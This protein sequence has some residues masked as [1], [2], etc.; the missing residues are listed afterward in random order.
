[1]SDKKEKSYKNLIWYFTSRLLFMIIAIIFISYGCS[2]FV[3]ASEDVIVD[4]GDLQVTTIKSYF[5]DNVFLFDN[6]SALQS[7]QNSNLTDIPFY[8][9]LSTG[10][11]RVYYPYDASAFASLF[12][13]DGDLPIISSGSF[14]YYGNTYNI[15]LEDYYIYLVPYERYD[16]SGN[17]VPNVDGRSYGVI[18]FKKSDWYFNKNWIYPFD[19]QQVHRVPACTFYVNRNDNKVHVDYYE[20]YFGDWGKN[21]MDTIFSSMP[22]YFS[23]KSII[24]NNMENSDINNDQSSDYLLNVN[25][26]MIDGLI[27]MDG[28]PIISVDPFPD[29]ESAANNLYFEDVQVGISSLNSN[30]DIIG[31]NYIIGVDVSDFVKNNIDDFYVKILITIRLK[32]SDLSINDPITSFNI[33]LPCKYF[34]NQ[35]YTVPISEVFANAPISGN[36]SNFLDY[37]RHIQ[38]THSVRTTSTLLGDRSGIFPTIL[39]TLDYAIGFYDVSYSTVNDYQIFDFDSDVYVFLGARSLNNRTSAPYTKHFDFLNGSENITDGSGL[40]NYDPWEGEEDPQ[41]QLDPYVPSY[42]SGGNN[43]NI[44]GGNTSVVVNNSGGKVPLNA[45][46]QTELNNII[47]RYGNLTKT[48]NDY[49]MGLANQSQDN[50]FLTVIEETLPM[51]PGINFM[52]ACACM[53]LGLAVILLV[54]KVLLF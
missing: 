8:G 51:I 13:F 34:L 16:H 15:S 4:A 39:N 36:Y 32:D 7:F 24:S 3:H 54:L 43:N 40:I 1:M 11:P 12:G 37:Y 38:S 46:S 45:H 49:F 35:V 44:S 10:N 19:G 20:V 53:A 6:N 41:N 18:Y 28:S 27:D 2:L 31:N 26:C 48:F 42:P 47:V 22:L 52:V 30:S 23:N 29:S 5:G 9:W 17:F 33:E 14:T 25:P 21:Y 50:N